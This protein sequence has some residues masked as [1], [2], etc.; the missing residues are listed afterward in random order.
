MFPTLGSPTATQKVEVCRLD[1]IF[2]R[3]V[4]DAPDPRVLLRIDT[5][6]YDLRV[7]EG[8]AGVLDRIVALQVDTPGG[9]GLHPV[10]PG[11]GYR[12]TI[13]GRGPGLTALRASNSSPALPASH[14]R[15]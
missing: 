3:V 6:G 12:R 8:A 9:A 4:G 10:P 11:R 5:Q 1:E 14:S 2:A 7:L 15:S 13:P